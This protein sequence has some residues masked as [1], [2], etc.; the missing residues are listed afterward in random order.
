MKPIRKLGDPYFPMIMFMLFFIIGAITFLPIKQ[1]S[2]SD[3]DKVFQITCI[4]DSTHNK[5]IFARDHFHG[6]RPSNFCRKCGGTQTYRNAIGRK[7]YGK[8]EILRYVE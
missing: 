3:Y 8:I 1:K 7:N 4:S 2:V 6:N 5:T